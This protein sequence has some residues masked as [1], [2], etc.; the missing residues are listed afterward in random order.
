VVPFTEQAI[1]GTAASDPDFGAYEVLATDQ[2][3]AANSLTP[4]AASWHMGS[5]GGWDAFSQDEK[6]LLVHNSWGGSSIL[7]LNPS[8]IHQHTCTTSPSP[9]CVIESG[10]YP[11]TADSTHLA[12]GG[13]FSFS[14]VPTETNILYELASPPTQINRLTICRYSTDPGC[15]GQSPNTLIRTPYIDFTSDA[16]GNCNVLMGSLGNGTAYNTTWTGSFQIGNDGSVAYGLGGGIDWAPSWTPTVNESFIVPTSANGG[17]GNHGY[18]ATAVTGPTGSTHPTWCS[19]AGCTVTDGGV[20]WSYIGG[21]GGQGPG[22][23]VVIY[24]PSQ[25]CTRLNTRIGKIYRG[26]GNFAPAGYMTTN[27]QI[28]CTRAANGGTPTYPC[29]MT[30]IFTLHEVEEQQNGRYLLFSP[31]GGEAPV[32]YPSWNSGTATC[33]ASSDTWRGAWSS[34]TTYANKDVISYGLL[35]YSSQANN[36][37]GNTPPPGLGSSNAYWAQTENLCLNYLLDTTTTLVQP[38]DDY[39]KCTGHGASGY[40]YRYYGK[41]YARSLFSDSIDPVETMNDGLKMLSVPGLP[42]DDHGTYRNANSSDAQAIFTSTTDVPGWPT[43]YTAAGYDELIGMLPDGSGVMYR[44]GHNW[45]TGSNATFAVQNAIGVIS[46]L[47][48]LMA[49]STDM[50]GTR[51]SNLQA[52]T[53]CQKLRGMFHPASGLLLYT[54][55]PNNGNIPDT[56]YPVT[57]NNGNFIY[58]TTAPGTT[59]GLTPSGGWCQTNGCTQS[60]GTATVQAIG[61]SDCRGDVVILDA[62]SAHK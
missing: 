14:R 4:Y 38:C 39:T 45:N 3:T 36:N 37:V 12:S 41:Y 23:D 58:Q 18:Q 24:R 19:T 22:F 60:W 9:N 56:V 16:H 42:C 31:T 62:L 40:K 17:S 47:G 49:F 7:Y 28:S 10:I 1:A 48:D 15:S 29:A 35:Y 52:N 43:R 20:T 61:P 55:D 57:G 2:T 34:T 11:G 33:Q 59:S 5:D 8:A 21:V 32:Q 27:D 25:G 50:M 51:G 54:S 30:D 26:T 46:P 6:L 13:S 53:T 44:F